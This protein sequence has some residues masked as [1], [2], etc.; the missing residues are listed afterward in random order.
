M[1]GELRVIT[2]GN[3]DLV[4][5][6]DRSAMSLRSAIARKLDK[7][8]EIIWTWY[9]WHTGREGGRRNKRQKG[10]SNA[11]KWFWLSFEMKYEKV[12]SFIL[13]SFWRPWF[14]YH[15]KQSKNMLRF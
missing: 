13:L 14:R 9:W 3:L 7:K 8:L 1:I 10:H 4:F 2:I 12:E 15:V 5:K 6:N 11:D